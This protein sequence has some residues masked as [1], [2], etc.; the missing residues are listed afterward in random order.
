MARAVRICSLLA[1]LAF[2]ANMQ[3]QDACYQGGHTS[4]KLGFSGVLEGEPFQGQFKE[5]SVRYCDGG[6]IEVRV[7]TGSASVGN[8]DGDEAL[9]SAEFFH[10]AV[11]PQATWTGAAT[12]ADGTPRQISGTLTV[13]GIGRS[14]PVTLTLER[15]GEG[16][17]MRGETT[18][19]RLDFDVGIG[20]FE[21]TSFIVNEVR[22][23]FDLALER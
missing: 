9:A 10:P 2:S 18:V 20:E 8:R 22:V 16:L 3:A 4:G 23:H 11:W 7:A 14:V 6:D 13:R 21:D 19:E 5:F 15:K 1:A 12:E 17:R